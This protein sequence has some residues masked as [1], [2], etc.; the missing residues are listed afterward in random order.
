MRKSLKA[1]ERLGN[2]PAIQGWTQLCFALTLCFSLSFWHS[3]AWHLYSHNFLVGS[4]QGTAGRFH[5]M[6]LRVGRTL[7]GAIPGNG[8]RMRE[9]TSFSF[10]LCS[11]VKQWFS[12]YCLGHSR[13]SL[14]VPSAL[15]SPVT[16][17]PLNLIPEWLGP[18]FQASSSIPPWLLEALH[19]A[20]QS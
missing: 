9:W 20:L 13:A 6:G 4:A 3:P 12:L 5:V 7:L 8:V 19:H 14:F 15:F 10:H 11:E 16:A 1:S 2:S 18:P 17:R